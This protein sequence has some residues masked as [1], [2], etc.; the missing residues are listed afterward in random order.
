[1]YWEYFKIAVKN[2][3]VRP[4]RSWL[5]IL[6]I[7]IG[8]FLVT[9][10]MSL[11]EGLKNS[12]MGELQTMG[13]DL[14]IVMPGEDMFSGL[15]GGNDL[16][17]ADLNGI[18]RTVGVETV[19]SMPWG[20]EIVRYKNEAKTVLITGISF[21]KTMTLLKEDMGWETVEGDFPRTGRREILLGN[22]VAKSI[23]P[24]IRVGDEVTIKGKRFY[25]SGYLRSLGNNQNDSMIMMD[26]EDYRT[27]TGKREGAPMTMAKVAPG[28]DVAEVVKNIEDSLEETR[29]RRV[30]EE[31]P[32]FSVISSD[33]VSDMVSSIMGILQVAIFAFASI[34]IIVGGIGVTNTMFTSVNERTKEI[35]ILKAVGAKRS[36]IVAI[37][38]FE[39]G[40]IGLIGGVLGVTLGVVASKGT[41]FVLA[42]LEQMFYLEAHIS[43][44][45]ILFGIAFSFFVGCISGYFPAKKAAMLEPVDALRYE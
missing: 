43:I 14:I 1:M 41:E 12:I 33:T 23:L 6:G 44:S 29:K 24:G 39:S 17:N 28:F 4:L 22:L 45:L 19:I 15:M 34:A 11:S 20:S 31:T 38:L 36:D 2:L 27:V 8:I 25:V 16:T 10:L 26:L 18:E 9:T 37:F 32:S 5:T 42:Q 3:R 35:G 21:D 40:I 30:G 7:V 13:G